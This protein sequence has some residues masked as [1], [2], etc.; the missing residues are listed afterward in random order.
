V[1]WAATVPLKE[2]VMS[3]K[4][5]GCNIHGRVRLSRLI[6]GQ[7]PQLLTPWRPNLV[8]YSWA[9]I[10]ANLLNTAAANYKLSGM[11]LEFKNVANAGDPV[12]PPSF[13]R[14]GGI[15]YYNGLSSSPDVDFLRVPI[16]ASG[17]TTSDTGATFSVFAK[18]QGAV[19]VNGKPYDNAH[20][21]KLY[22]A[23]VVAIVDPAD[24]TRDLVFSRYYLPTDEQQLKL[25]TGQLGIEWAIP[26]E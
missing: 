21:S 14:T 25:A 23:A 7:P 5:V 26:L 19:G 6:E 15:A 4:I 9:E 20:H 16:L 8:V 2:N 12:T 11:L 1:L 10:V 17:V 18:D 13:D 24:R 22:G 3:E